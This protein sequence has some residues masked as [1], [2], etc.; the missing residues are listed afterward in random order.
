MVDVAATTGLK[1]LESLTFKNK[2]KIKASAMWKLVNDITTYKYS[3]SVSFFTVPHCIKSLINQNR[4][5]KNNFKP[6]LPFLW[7]TSQ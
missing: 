3:L 5:H 6:Q 1:A 7:S 2:K 4:V